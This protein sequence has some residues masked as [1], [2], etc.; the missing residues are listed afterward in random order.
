MSDTLP[1]SSRWYF[2]WSLYFFIPGTWY[3]GQ[4]LDFD[5]P[6]YIARYCIIAALIQDSI[7]D[8]SVLLSNTNHGF[9]S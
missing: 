8:C 6:V 3:I 9:L 4:F 7:F 5:R 1:W 2:W